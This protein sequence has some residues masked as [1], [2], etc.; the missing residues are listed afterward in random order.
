MKRIIVFSMF[1][2]AVLLWMGLTIRTSSS[3][4]LDPLKLIR[5]MH[6]STEKIKNMR[7]HLYA[8]EKIRDEYLEADSDIKLQLNPKKI[9]FKNPKKGIEILFREGEH[10]NQALVYPNMFPY[11][12][13]YL[14]P[15]GSLIRKNQHYTI[16]ELGYKFISRT[17]KSILK[18]DPENMVKYIHY[19]GKQA[20]AGESCHVVTYENENFSYH[21]YVVGQNE[22]VSLLAGRNFLSDYMI[23][24]KNNLNGFYGYIKAGKIIRLPNSYCKKAVLFLNDKNLLPVAIDVYDENGLWES[25]VYSSVQI[26]GQL[27]DSE[28]TRNYPGYRF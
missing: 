20:R 3:T 4:T 18:K 15:V 7:F 9:Y 1:F 14:D 13:I 11:A 27:E 22:N 24:E 26:N 19:S 25:Y 10:N 21:D 16:H 28:F 2:L 8:K 23:R 12:S 5:Q 17:I 6:D